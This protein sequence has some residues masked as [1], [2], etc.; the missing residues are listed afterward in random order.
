[1]SCLVLPRQDYCNTVLAGIPLH[2]ARRLQSVMNAAARLVFA[3]LKCD[4]ITPLLR[5]LHWLKVP[6]RIDY[7]LAVLVYKCLHGLAP[8]YL[9]DELHHPTESKFRRRLCSASSHELSVSRARLSTYGD[10]VFP[11]VA[12]LIW[13]SLPQHITSAPSLPV[14]CSRLKT[15]FFE[16]CYP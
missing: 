5:Q 3:S 13:N 8:S 4:H 1:V 16:L 6:W 14:F 2:L 10:R 9:A 15:Y 11:V 12:V 7:K